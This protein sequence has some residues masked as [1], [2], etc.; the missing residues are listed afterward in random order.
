M[1]LKSNGYL[2]LKM[3]VTI[4]SCDNFLTIHSD[5]NGLAIF[6]SYG[7]TM[8][9]CGS[10]ESWIQVIAKGEA[11]GMVSKSVGIALG[12]AL[13]GYVGSSG[14]PLVFAFGVVTAFHIFC[15]L[16]SYQAVQLRTLNPYRASKF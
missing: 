9:L 8:C 11:Q 10:F 5:N 14:A 4:L 2:C 12:I 16:K 1:E 13:S 6:L 15:N 7:G 3:F